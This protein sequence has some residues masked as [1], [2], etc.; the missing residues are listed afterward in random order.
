M[1]P[2]A[3]LAGR[4]LGQDFAGK[5][6]WR[7]Y[8]GSTEAACIAG[9]L[10]QLEPLPPPPDWYCDSEIAGQNAPRRKYSWGETDGFF[11]RARR[12]EAT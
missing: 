9:R 2:A 11:R 12:E 1:G 10:G 6:G 4:D 5:D 3:S 7:I 8:R